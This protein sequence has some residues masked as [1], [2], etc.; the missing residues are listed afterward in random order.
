M[1]IRFFGCLMEDL[2]PGLV[3]SPDGGVTFLG[4]LVGDDIGFA[5]DWLHLEVGQSLVL[6]RT[7]LAIGVAILLLSLTVNGRKIIR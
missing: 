5:V 2:L 4:K 7:K 1:S 6:G 3:T